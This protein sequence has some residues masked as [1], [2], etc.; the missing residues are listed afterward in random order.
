MKRFFIALIVF[1]ILPCT[2][3]GA[4]FSSEEYN[5]ALSSYDLS[6]FEDKLDGETYSLLKELSLET[7]SFENIYNLKLRDILNIFLKTA[8][9][10][11]KYPLHGLAEISVFI[12]LSS[13]FKAIKPEKSS[14]SELYSTVT[15]LFI[16]VIL[17]YEIGPVITLAVSSISVSADFIY[18]FIP[19][20]CAIVTASGGITVGFSTNA[21]LLSLSQGLAFI[22][23]AIVTPVINSFLAI[24][25][26]SSLRPQ[27]NL[28]N[29][30][31][32]AK[33]VITWLMA[34]VAGAYVSVLSIKTAAAGRAD[35]LGIR[36]LR[37]VISSVVPVIGGALSEGLL[38]I[39][40]YSSLIKSSVGIVGIIAVALVFIPSVIEIVLWRFILSLGS[41]ICEVFNDS[42]VASVIKVFSSALLLINVLLIIS[43]LTTVV[44]IGLLI[45]S[46]S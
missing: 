9:K 8:E 35:M 5:D 46:G 3:Y 28:S 2:V 37:F 29:I 26:C 40:T 39:Q 14:L 12:I 23:S 41:I 10:G 27:L 25:I 11:I 30:A 34:F 43:A 17:I 20:F 24:G 18:A 6:F 13:M 44:S 38:S 22:G 21:L 16:S 31:E 1:M 42:A 4:D 15:A 19:V 33:R 7:F 36:S 32:A 45:A